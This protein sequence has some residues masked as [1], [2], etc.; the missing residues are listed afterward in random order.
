MAGPTLTPFTSAPCPR[1]EVFF[2]SF[3][4]GTAT[5]TVYRLAGGREFRV[6]GAV[7]TPVSGALSRLDFE[8][9]FGMPV[10][11]RAEQ[12]NAAGVSL[13]FTDSSSLTVDSED[14]WMHNPLNPA[15]AVS[16]ALAAASAPSVTRPTPGAVSRPLGRVVGVVL[17]QP[18]QGVTGLQIVVRTSSDADADLVQGMVGDD[19]TPP[20][21]C[22]RLGRRDGRMRV[23]QP[24]F[25]STLTV[26]E[27]ETS[28]EDIDNL[29]EHRFQ[30]DEVDPPTPGLYVPLLRRKDLDAFFATRSA[31][32]ASALKRSDLDRRYDLAGFG[33]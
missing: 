22:L 26:E 15:G 3:V 13:G 12:F 32:N 27:V 17:S 29:L 7:R 19:R 4:A 10:T 25:L 23:P 8:V 20:V 31:M 24:L 16:V 6:R 11:Y 14:S 2:A 33:G 1:V 30:G 5:V 18:R 21:V 28:F 9:P